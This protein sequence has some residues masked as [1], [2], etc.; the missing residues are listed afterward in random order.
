MT[1]PDP[2]QQPPV[3]TPPKTFTQDEV[4]AFLAEDR[5]KVQARYAD[6][7]DLKT[8]ASK[9][10][11]IERNNLS[12][13]ERLRAESERIANDLA[14]ERATRLRLEIASAHEITGDDLVL[15][16]ATDEETLRAQAA[17]IQAKNTA[18]ATAAG[19]APLPGQGTPATAPTTGSVAAGEDLYRQ[20][21]PKT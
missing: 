2:A 1:Q 20:L 15:L 3:P 13:V 10:D 16:T 12:E 14:T 6:Y 18:A 7:D 19:S 9:L 21:H 17:R 4:N 8:K 11:E 5:R